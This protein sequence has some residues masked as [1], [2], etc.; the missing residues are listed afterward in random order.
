MNVNFYEELEIQSIGGTK[1]SGLGLFSLFFPE[2]VK[3]S[4]PPGCIYIL[5]ESENCAVLDHYKNIYK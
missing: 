3:S 1:S 4:S 2:E 5:L